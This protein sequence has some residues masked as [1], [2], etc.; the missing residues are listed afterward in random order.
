M[1]II[2]TDLD[3]TLLDH[4]TYSYD[5]ALPALA[6][7]SDLC[8]P[9]VI[10]TSKTRAEVELWRTRLKNRHP[11]IVENGGALCVPRNYFPLS[12]NAPV[13]RG[14]YGVIE[15]GDSYEELVNTLCIASAES[16]IRVNGF[17]QLSTEAVAEMCGM[18]IAQAMLAKQREYDEPFEILDSPAERLLCSIKN[19]GKRWTRGGRF[20]HI[21]GANDKAHCVSLLTHYYREVFGDVTSVGLGDGLND[22]A[23][24]NVVDIPIV[25]P[26]AASEQLRKVVPRCR[27][28]HS[29]GPEGWK[30][31]VLQILGSHRPSA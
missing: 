16:G 28:A 4:D 14:D 13:W 1:I 11:F 6:V 17:H 31:A 27:L 26:S 15:L 19:R 30:D 21:T 10:C 12:F 7:I 29:P 18:S 2:F 9:L 22:A 23:F 20:Y 3:G 25:L 24:L 8:V 5:A